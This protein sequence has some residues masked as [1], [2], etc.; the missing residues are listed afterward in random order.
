MGKGCLLDSTAVADP[1]RTGAVRVS[2][3]S[4]DGG[5]GGAKRDTSV[6]QLSQGEGL[7]VAKTPVAGCSRLVSLGSTGLEY[8]LPG[9]AIVGA[10]KPS[11]I[12]LSLIGA[13]P[14]S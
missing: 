6:L 13:L 2:V 10:Q 1:D 9:C 14:F 3:V 8:V 11:C 4:F 7:T 12:G 5:R